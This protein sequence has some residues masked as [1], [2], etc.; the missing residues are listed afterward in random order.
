MGVGRESNVRATL[1]RGKRPVIRSIGGW[2]GPRANVGGCR[3]YRAS[4]RCFVLSF[5]FIRL[6][7]PAFCLLLTTQ[8]FMPPARFE[9]T[10]PSS[11]RPQTL[12]LDRS[13]TGMGRKFQRPNRKSNPRPFVLYCSTSTNCDT[14]YPR[15]EPRTVRIVACRYTY[16]KGKRLIKCGHC[17][18]IPHARHKRSG[19]FS[20]IDNIHNRD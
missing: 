18:E 17:T 20:Y 8:T 12:A 16:C 5:H 13:A 11:D 9:P 7:C 14:A 2:V 10:T 19:F 15:L 1:H 3:K 4:P 6:D